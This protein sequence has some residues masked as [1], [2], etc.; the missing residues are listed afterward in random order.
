[1]NKKILSLFVFLS[2]G[3]CVL[4]IQFN[5]I[6]SRLIKTTGALDESITLYPTEP[7]GNHNWYITPVNVTFH[8]KDNL[9]LAYIYYKITTED[10]TKPTWT[11]VDIRN[12]HTAQYDLTISINEDGVHIAIFYTVDHI[13]NIGPT[14]TSDLIRIDMSSPEVSLR[15]EQLSLYD[16]KFTANTTDII[17]GIYT[18]KFYVNDETKP[19]SEDTTPPYEFAWKRIP[20]QTITTQA[21]DEAGNEAVTK[22]T[23]SKCLVFGGNAKVIDIHSDSKEKYVDIEVLKKPLLIWEDEKITIN[24]GGFVRLYQANGVFLLSFPMCF[25]ISVDWEIIN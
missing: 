5:A 4:L 16:M 8:A 18:V 13:G 6:G 17:S 24:L 20:I 2:I 19:T 21:Y 12:K 25:G 9:Q 14:H 23:T 22:K 10:Q 7:N 11:Q 1:M 15:K 3:L